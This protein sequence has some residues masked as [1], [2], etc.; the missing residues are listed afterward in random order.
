MT[1]KRLILVLINHLSNRL[2]CVVEPM[3]STTREQTWRLPYNFLHI[4]GM[5]I[6]KPLLLALFTIGLALN[7]T[8]ITQAQDCSAQSDQDWWTQA[9]N[10]YNLGNYEEALAA[11]TCMIELD[12]DLV[13]EGYEW[14]GNTYR[15]LD[16]YDAAL[17]D[18]NIAVT[19]PTNRSAYA[20]RA[21]LHLRWGYNQLALDDYDRSIQNGYRESSVY[22]NRGV[23]YFRL[24]DKER[25]RSDFSQATAVDPDNG[26]A[27]INLGELDFYFGDIDSSRE[28]IDTGISRSSGS[29]Q[30]FGYELRGMLNYVE[31]DFMAAINDLTS[32]VE[33]DPDNSVAYSNRALVYQATG[34]PNANADYLKYVQA[35]EDEVI[36][37]ADEDISWQGYFMDMAFGKIYRSSYML[38]A[39]QYF[40]V[41][42]TAD[43]ESDVDPLVVLLGPSGTAVAADDDSGSNKNAVINRFLVPQDGIYTLLVTHGKNESSGR[44]RFRTDIRTDRFQQFVSTNLILGERGKIF[45]VGNDGPGAINLRQYPATGFE[46]LTQL[47][48][49]TEVNII[50]GPYKDV[51]FVWWQ[52]ETDDGT[53][54]WIVE[55]LSGIQILSLAIEVGDTVRIDTAELNFRSEPSVNGALVQSLFREARAVL[56][57]VEG[58]I[59]ADGFTWWKVRVAGDNGFEA[60]AVD[61]VGVNPTLAVVPGG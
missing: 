9:E 61:R 48:S 7:L 4:Q 19:D 41:E 1:L 5:G 23:V 2:L 8:T 28:N 51:D 15:N 25:S 18:L 33:V 20:S 44:M 16:D 60:W 45:S 50:N 47:E 26:L 56:T 13:S 43:T 49:G 32:S 59:E 31:G 22:N 37:V 6:I 21:F 36:D 35:I 38:S 27:L 12:G 17:A 29:Q 14:R 46:V 24:G 52:V 57:V 39:G 58:P 11:Y 30:A 10:D 54:G 53:S 42:A 34:S 40:T 3:C 55:Y